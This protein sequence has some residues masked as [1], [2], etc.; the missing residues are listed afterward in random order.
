MSVRLSICPSVRTSVSPCSYLCRIFAKKAISPTKLRKSLNCLV[1]TS[2]RTHLQRLYAN[3][4]KIVNRFAF[5]VFCL[6]PITHNTYT[7]YISTFI[8]KTE[9]NQPRPLYITKHED[10]VIFLIF[11]MINGGSASK[12]YNLLTCFFSF[13][14]RKERC[15]QFT[16]YCRL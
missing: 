8:Q 9:K 14:L 13:L 2:Q 7:I 10:L 11:F 12:E 16:F 3:A 6:L 15:S 1:Q 5:G 4:T